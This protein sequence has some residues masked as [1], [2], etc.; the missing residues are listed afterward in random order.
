MRDKRL[1]NGGLIS[2][3]LGLAKVSLVNKPHQAN[4]LCTQ[5]LSFFSLILWT[6]LLKDKRL[7]SGTIEDRESKASETERERER[8]IQKEYTT[9]TCVE[10]SSSML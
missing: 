10:E 5:Q 4:N 3:S 9:N 7:T 1:H 8:E 2:A 6:L